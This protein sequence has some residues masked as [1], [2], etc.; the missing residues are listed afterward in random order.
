MDAASANGNV[1][2]LQWWKESGLE[3]KWS[4][5][6]LYQASQNGHVHVLQWWEDS[7]LEMGE[8]WASMR[9]AVLGSELDDYEGAVRD[10]W[11]QFAP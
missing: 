11:E 6:A 5:Y 8:M 10:W 3:L 1:A 7:G 9:S 4:E 2:V